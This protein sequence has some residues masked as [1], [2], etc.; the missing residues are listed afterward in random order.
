MTVDCHT[1]NEIS[2]SDL[3]TEVVISNYFMM[4]GVQ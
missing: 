2:I 1:S 4:L 3:H